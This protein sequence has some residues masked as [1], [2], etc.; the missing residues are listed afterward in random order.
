M[1][2]VEPLAQVARLQRHEHL[3]TARK[4]QHDATGFSS[5]RT[6]AAAHPTWRRSAISTRAPGKCTT[7]GPWGLSADGCADSIT[8][9]SHCSLLPA[10]AT[11]FVEELFPCCWCR[12]CTH[13]DEKA[14]LDSVYQL[15]PITREILRTKGHDC[16]QFS[17]IAVIVLNQIVRPFTAKWH[18]E[19]LAGAL[20][21]PKKRSEFRR[22]LAA[23]QKDLRHYSK[24]LADIARVE[25]LTALSFN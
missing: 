6:N 7:S 25:D 12:R 18:R 23:L 1:Q 13:G 14:A 10:C 8:A 16:I 3:Q 5:A 2:T 15:F 19:S 21:N 11:T 17:K 9:S 22:E 20:K 24:A 4:T